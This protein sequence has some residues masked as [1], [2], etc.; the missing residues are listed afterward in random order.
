MTQHDARAAMSGITTKE[1]EAAVS[2][3]LQLVS[4]PNTPEAHE[5][6]RHMDKTGNGDDARRASYHS[7]VLG[8]KGRAAL[9]KAMENAK[10]DAVKGVNFIG[11]G[12]NVDGNP[13]LSASERMTYINDHVGKNRRDIER[14]LEIT[15]TPE[16]SNY[17]MMLRQQSGVYT[18]HKGV[19][20]AFAHRVLLPSIGSVTAGSLYEENMRGY[21]DSMY[22]TFGS[23]GKMLKQALYH[24]VREMEENRLIG[25]ALNENKG[26]LEGALGTMRS[27]EY[28]PGSAFGLLGQEK[29]LA[30]LED[31]LNKLKDSAKKIKNSADTDNIRKT[32]TLSIAL[33]LKVNT[34]LEHEHLDEAARKLAMKKL[35]E[36]HD[37]FRKLK[38]KG[39]IANVAHLNVSADLAEVA[40][41]YDEAVSTGSWKTPK[42]KNLFERESEEN[43]RVALKATKGARPGGAG[44]GTFFAA[45]TDVE[46]VDEA[47]DVLVLE[48]INFTK[49]MRVYTNKKGTKTKVSVTAASA[50]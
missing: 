49:L 4:T 13:I 45:A 24:M 36:S 15:A 11:E 3:V 9:D 1:G 12:K 10:R 46:P 50:I 27:Y 8:P 34:M 20:S 23:D 19:L 17:V 7:R 2:V 14:R 32:S 40:K 18:F 6:V 35:Y 26:K 41:A 22:S 48:I 44:I 5:A 47:V 39:K 30:S 21:L 38:N 42:E 33:A 16:L 31:S 37:V 28:E 43:L 25:N 29:L